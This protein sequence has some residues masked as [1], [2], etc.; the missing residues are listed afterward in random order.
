MQFGHW[1][2]AT[3]HLLNNQQ[4]TTSDALKKAGDAKLDERKLHA[5]SERID[6][7]CAHPDPIA[8]AK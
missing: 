3:T 2:A 6:A 7:L 4:D 1:R 5:M 8:Q